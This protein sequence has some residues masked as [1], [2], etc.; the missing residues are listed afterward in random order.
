MT[1]VYYEGSGSFSIG[2]SVEQSPRSVKEIVAQ[3]HG[4]VPLRFDLGPCGFPEG[5]LRAGAVGPREP[6]D[7]EL[8]AA[9]ITRHGEKRI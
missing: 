6:S 3:R 4:E 2:E 9:E 5:L 8:G 1:A 7:A